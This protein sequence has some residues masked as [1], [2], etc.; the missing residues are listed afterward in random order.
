MGEAT[1]LCCWEFRSHCLSSSG[2][3]V[4]FGKTGR[5]G[6]ISDRVKGAI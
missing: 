4:S 2:H 6:L 1:I 5:G 3:S